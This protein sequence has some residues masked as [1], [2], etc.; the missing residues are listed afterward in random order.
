MEQLENK[1]IV[2]IRKGHTRD[3]DGQ[4]VGGEWQTL[5][6][7]SGCERM[8]DYYT[9]AYRE[10]KAKCP[11]TEMFGHNVGRVKE[12]VMIERKNKDTRN[13]TA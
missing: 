2:E 5:K 3:T 6:D 9:Q 11:A 13:G 12:V 4:F 8:F 10:L 7:E 1:F